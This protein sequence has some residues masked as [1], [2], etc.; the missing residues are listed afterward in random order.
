V[1]LPLRDITCRDDW[2]F[3]A[4]T[5][6]ISTENFAAISLRYPDKF[7]EKWEKMQGE[8]FRHAGVP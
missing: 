3:S 4:A 2:F 1:W 5:A 6:G 8:F 7:F